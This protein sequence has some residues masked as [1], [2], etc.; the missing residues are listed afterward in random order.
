MNAQDIG[1]IQKLNSKFDTLSKDV[2]DI[3]QALIGNKFGDNGLVRRVEHLELRVQ[4]IE[5]WKMKIIGY[6]A[7]AAAVGATGASALTNLIL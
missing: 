7:G 6:A 3:K 4:E 1:Q 2:A 5:Y